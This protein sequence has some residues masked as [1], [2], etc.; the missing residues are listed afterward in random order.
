MA[1]VEYE[2]VEQELWITQL[3]IDIYTQRNKNNRTQNLRN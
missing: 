2:V 3:L 1:F